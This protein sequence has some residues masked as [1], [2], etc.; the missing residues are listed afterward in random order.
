[1]NNP[2]ENNAFEALRLDPAASN[3]EVVAQAARLRQRA[4]DE[5]ELAAVRRAVQALTGRPEDRELHEALTHPGPCYHSPGTDQL[6]AA[7][8]R[9]PPATGPPDPTPPFDLAGF[10]DLLRLLAG[11]HY[12]TLALPLGPVDDSEPPEEIHRQNVE[13]RWQCLPD[14]FSA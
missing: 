8:R 13:A 4:A 2:Y 10:A 3:E 11:G 12:D 6:R 1:M 9:P 7:F 14:E 5:A